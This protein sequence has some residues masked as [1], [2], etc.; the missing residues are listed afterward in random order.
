[1]SSQK[2]FNYSEFRFFF[3]YVL[4]GGVGALLDFTTFM[5]LTIY[6][7]NLILANIISTTVGVLVSFHLNSRHTFY[8]NTTNRI[9]FFRFVLVG[10]FGMMLSTVVLFVQIEIFEFRSDFSKILSLPLIA[11]FQFQLNRSWTFKGI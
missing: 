11:I 6:G 1:M 10:L 2:K 3:R 9:Q 4:F 8:L 5:I 7:T